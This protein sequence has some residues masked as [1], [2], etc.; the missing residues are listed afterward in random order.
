MTTP[1]NSFVSEFKIISP[2]SLEEFED[3]NYNLY[4][5]FI[6]NEASKYWMTTQDFESTL[7]K[8]FDII[9]ASS[10]HLEQRL[11]FGN[12]EIEVDELLVP[13]IEI[14]NREEILTVQCCQYNSSGY[15]SIEFS[16]DGYKKW[17]NLLLTKAIEKYGEDCYYDCKILDRI[18]TNEIERKMNFR[19]I[20]DRS[21]DNMIVFTSGIYHGVKEFLFTVNWMFL[22]DDIDSIV[23]ELSEL[24]E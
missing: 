10:P 14:I 9:K 11:T 21:I 20:K 16:F 23:K 15:S 8:D 24:F 12:I 19:K 4:Q 22:Q 3:I 7:H 6:K 2:S 18:S 17:C 13:L 5:S 1:P